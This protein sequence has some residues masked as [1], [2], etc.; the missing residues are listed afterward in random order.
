IGTSSAATTVSAIEMDYESLTGL[1]DFTLG[2]DKTLR[3]PNTGTVKGHQLVDHSTRKIKDIVN[4]KP[5]ALLSA[6]AKTTSGGRDVSNKDGRLA[7]KPWC[8]AHANIGSSSQKVISEHSANHSHEIDLQR[9]E[10]GQGT[11]NL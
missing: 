10:L 2:K 7:T 9:L 5:F 11:A 8:F 1:Q 4:A 6:Q 3:Y